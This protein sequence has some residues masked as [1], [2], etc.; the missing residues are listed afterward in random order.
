MSKPMEEGSELPEDNGETRPRAME[1]RSVEVRCGS[2]VVTP[3]RRVSVSEGERM[4]TCIRFL[5]YASP[6]SKE[7]VDPRLVLETKVEVETEVTER[8][9]KES[10]AKAHVRE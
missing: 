6:W 3:R 7:I 4:L 2:E 5:A 10:K 9:R 8:R 1:K